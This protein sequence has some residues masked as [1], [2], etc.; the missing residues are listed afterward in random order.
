MM[1]TAE[2]SV[3]RSALVL[4]SQAGGGDDCVYSGHDMNQNHGCGNE[5]NDPY[6][7]AAKSELPDPKSQD[8]RSHQDAERLP[9]P[10]AEGKDC[11]KLLA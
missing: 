6:T 9:D 2:S 5:N 10:F 1:R 3:S 7:C 11:E 8:R 4:R